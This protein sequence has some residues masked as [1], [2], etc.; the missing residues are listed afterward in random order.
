M[1]PGVESQN[2]IF[3]MSNKGHVF[4]FHNSKFPH[5]S[6]S[7]L[8][9]SSRRTSSSAP[10]MFSNSV[11]LV[12]L[13]PLF[14]YGSHIVTMSCWEVQCRKTVHSLACLP[15]QIKI[16][17]CKITVFIQQSESAL[18]GDLLDILLYVQNH[19]NAVKLSVISFLCSYIC[20]FN[21]PVLVSWA[22]S[23]VKN[24][25]VNL[26]PCKLWGSILPLGSS[27]PAL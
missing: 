1:F 27:Q 5:M 23:S 14:L 12:S 7:L 21:L 15:C 8:Q 19:H 18:P 16:I 24:P 6:A 22:Q 13:L 3:F 2:Q 9:I 10:R 26:S 17:T 4:M 25:T 20:D 11:T